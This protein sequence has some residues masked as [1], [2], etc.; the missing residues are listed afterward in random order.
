[1]KKVALSL[2]ALAVVGTG[3]FAA[4]VAAESAAAVS[5]TLSASATAKLGIDLSTKTSGFAHSEDFKLGFNIIDDKA[6]NKTGEGDV[7]GTIEVA[8][9]KIQGDT[10]DGTDSTPFF[11]SLGDITAK[12]VFPNGFLKINENIDPSVGYGVDG[13]NDNGGATIVADDSFYTYKNQYGKDSTEWAIGTIPGFSAFSGTGIEA[14]Y[15]LPKLVGLTLDVGSKG[16]W[17]AN[18]GNRYEAA[19]EASLK[20]VDKLTVAVKG[21]YGAGERD[22][23][24]Q[25]LGASV[26]YDLGILVP[27]FNLNTVGAYNNHTDAV[28]KTWKF[29]AATGTAIQDVAAVAGSDVWDDDGAYAA[30]FGTKFPLVDGLTGN[31]AG[32]YT[33]AGTI[34]AVVTTKLAANKL[35]GPLAVLAGVKL[36]NV[37]SSVDKDATKTTEVFANVSAT[38]DKVTVWGKT[39]YNTS[40][41]DKSDSLFLK[42]GADVAAFSLTTVGAEWDSSD[43]GGAKAQGDQNLGQAFVYVKVAY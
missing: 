42:A 24:V 9:L 12:V 36:G 5:A 40:A 1:M 41:A 26:G 33:S 3:A 39:S 18:S 29:D 37:T 14:Y 8:D 20:A 15:E 30:D 10:E 31:V 32:T 38:F 16:D 43:F 21:Y 17:T 4:D 6:S 13:D 34:N 35:V 25:G 7:H 28:A 23:A 19:L 27:Y 2:L 11:I 22:K